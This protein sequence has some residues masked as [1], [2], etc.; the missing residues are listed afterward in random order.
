MTSKS[1]EIKFA[2]LLAIEIHLYENKEIVD[3][4][5]ENSTKKKNSKIL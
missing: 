3:Q 5:V 4:S 1:E 2:A